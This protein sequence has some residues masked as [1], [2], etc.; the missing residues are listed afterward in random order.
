MGPYPRFR[1]RRIGNSTLD[2]LTA[3]AVQRQGRVLTG[4]TAPEMGSTPLRPLRVRP[5][6]RPILETTP[7]IDYVGNRLASEKEARGLH[8]ERLPRRV[9]RDQS[10]VG[11][12]GAVEDLQV[13]LEVGYRVAQ[14]PDRPT[15]K[16]NAVWRPRPSP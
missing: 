5:R 8:R 3:E 7:G 9:G 12:R 6:R 2:D 11:S 1:Y 14:Q 13:L 16:P 4:D 10:R 15:W